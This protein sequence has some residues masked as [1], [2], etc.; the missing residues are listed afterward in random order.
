MS[1]WVSLICSYAAFVLALVILLLFNFFEIH[2]DDRLAATEFKRQY[3][4][5]FAM[6]YVALFI[7]LIAGSVS[8]YC[9]FTAIV[10]MSDCAQ[11]M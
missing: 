10:P 1:T 11:R 5:E 2:V 6:N 4:T 9:S 8:G 3:R 7:S